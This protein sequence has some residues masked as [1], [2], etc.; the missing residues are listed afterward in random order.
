MKSVDQFTHLN[1]NISS[2]ESDVSLRK[3][4]NNV[5]KHWQY[6]MKPWKIK[7]ETIFQK[8]NIFFQV[9]LSSKMIIL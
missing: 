6:S 3:N 2:T 8:A 9:R 1:S 5:Q 7:R 4:I